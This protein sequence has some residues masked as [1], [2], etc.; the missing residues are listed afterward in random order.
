MNTQRR[1]QGQESSVVQAQGRIRRS[2]GP[3]SEGLRVADVMTRRQPIVPSHISM[4]AARKIAELKSSDT[5]IVEDKGSLLGF[6][7]SESLRTGGDDQRVAE[8]L[9]PLR[10]CV[11]PNTTVEEAHAM[12]VQY[13]VTSLPVSVGPFLVGSISR[14]TVERVLRAGMRSEERRVGKE[15]Y[16]LCRSRWS[17]YH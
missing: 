12:L 3:S 11:S 9:K 13:G 10:P 16:A 2:G 17:P 5:L 1:E 8:C 15:C 4:A 7:D 6:L 14:S